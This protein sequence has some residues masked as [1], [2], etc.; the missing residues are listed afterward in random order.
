VPIELPLPSIERLRRIGRRVHRTYR[1][2]LP[3]E[4]AM[5][6]KQSRWFFCKIDT[7][8]DCAALLH[9]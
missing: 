2:L 9:H 8:R 5:V 4:L 6:R 1:S 3:D 7:F